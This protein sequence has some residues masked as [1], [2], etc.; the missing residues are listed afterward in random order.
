MDSESLRRSGL[1]WAESRTPRCLEVLGDINMRVRGSG[2][3]S[4]VCEGFAIV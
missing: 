1:P 4:A 3:G 2:F